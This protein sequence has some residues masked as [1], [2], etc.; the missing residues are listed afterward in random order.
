MPY[1]VKKCKV[2]Y[3]QQLVA[4]VSSNYVIYEPYFVKCFR[5]V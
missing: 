3:S 5:D 4:I 2:I 1:S